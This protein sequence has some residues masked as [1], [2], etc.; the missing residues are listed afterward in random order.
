MLKAIVFTLVM[1]TFVSAKTIRKQ[2]VENEVLSQF[3]Q[4]K[5]SET[6][7]ETMNLLIH[8]NE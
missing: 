2:T 5:S 8:L 6:E 4:N 7:E 3:L 1:L